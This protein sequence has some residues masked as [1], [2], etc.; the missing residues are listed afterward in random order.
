MD[1]ALGAV[2]QNGILNRAHHAAS[3]AWFIKIFQLVS[4]WRQTRDI[5]GPTQLAGMMPR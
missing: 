4:T 2:R 5:D 3:N 1:C